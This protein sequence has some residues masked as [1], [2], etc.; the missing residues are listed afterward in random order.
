MKYTIEVRGL[1]RS[2]GEVQALSGVDLAAAR[3]TVLGV[4]GPNGAGKT[5]AVRVMSTLTRPDAGTARVLGLDETGGEVA[6]AEAAQTGGGEFD[7]ERQAV[8]RG[9]YVQD[10]GRVRLIDGEVPVALEGAF[11]EE[12]DRRVGSQLGQGF[13]V[14]GQREG[15]DAEDRFA[16]DAEGFAAGGEDPQAGDAPEEVGQECGGPLDEVLAVVDHEHRVAAPQGLGQAREGFLAAAGEDRLAEAEGV[17][18]RLGD[19]GRV[20]DGR[21]FDQA[22]GLAAGREPVGGLDGEAGFAGAA[23]AGEGDE[24]VRAEQVEEGVQFG[25]AADAG[26]Q[27][28]RQAVRVRWRRSRFDALRTSS[29]AAWSIAEGSTPSS[30]TSWARTWS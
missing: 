8:E 1:R 6:E 27:G 12:P 7:G 30:S 23:W 16:G 21:E 4:L 18:D 20:G 13:G 19:P 2:F 15:P 17:D 3:G 26:G 24:P 22:D 25:F 29:R 9:A 28:P 14:R 10:G 11:L 5:T